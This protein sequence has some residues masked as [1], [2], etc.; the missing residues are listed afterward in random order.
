MVA[1]INWDEDK[2]KFK[3]LCQLH[4]KRNKKTK[5]NN[6]RDYLSCCF[7]GQKLFCCISG[8]FDRKSCRIKIMFCCCF[9]WIT[10]FFFVLFYSSIRKLQCCIWNIICVSLWRWKFTNVLMFEII[11]HLGQIKDQ[12]DCITIWF[13]REV[14]W[15]ISNDSIMTSYNNFHLLQS[16][17]KTPTPFSNYLQQFMYIFQG[18]KNIVKSLKNL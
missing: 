8:D 9:L 2:K 4:E 6:K 15:K 1:Q 18:S 14:L 12:V 16:V 17:I 3:L 13:E 11:I 5:Q 10:F 7:W